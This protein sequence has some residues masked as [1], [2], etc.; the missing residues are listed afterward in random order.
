MVANT[1]ATTTDRAASTPGGAATAQKLFVFHS[2]FWINLHH[3]LYEEAA[4]EEAGPRPTAHEPEL[5]SDSSVTAT[6]NDDERRDWAAAVSYY[7]TNII[8]RDLLK[9]DAMRILKNRLEDRE[10]SPTLAGANIDPPLARVLGRAAPIYRAHWWPQHD[11]ANHAWIDGVTL[12]VVK[13]GAALAQSLANAY[14]TQWPDTPLRVD[15]VAYANWAG[16]Y[17]TLRP[18]RSVISSTDEGNQGIA[19]L[20]VLFH[21]A[22]HP[23]IDK[24]GD[25]LIRDFAARKRTPPLD[26]WHAVLFFTTGFFVQQIYPN[27]MPYA[28]RFDLWNR[29]GWSSYRELLVKDWQPRLE[30]K[31]RLD[32]ALSQLAADYT[33]TAN[34]S[35]SAKE[36]RR[37]P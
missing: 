8:E 32:T 35:P 1:S 23:L 24:V 18:T 27:Y 21:E 5:A 3:F 12:L 10:N 25:S 22:S 31:V 26:L 14:E 36:V 34:A 19:G 30:G 11:R 2:G 9:N 37:R 16:A 7:R 13:N 33:S 15:V 20:E 28:D 6:L 29:G 17:T 4:A